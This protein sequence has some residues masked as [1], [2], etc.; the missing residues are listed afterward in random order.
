MT[1]RQWHHSNF[2]D[3]LFK[4][5]PAVVLF[6]WRGR[7]LTGQPGGQVVYFHLPGTIFTRHGRAGINFVPSQG[8]K[9]FSSSIA[10]I[11]SWFKYLFKTSD[12]RFWLIFATFLG[13]CCHCI[14]LNCSRCQKQ[15]LFRD[16]SLKVSIIWCLPNSWGNM[17]L[18]S[19]AIIIY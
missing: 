19:F 1:E 13:V 2:N 12:N 17:I 3:Y 11:L 15:C 5:L 8:V 14:V 10:V 4:F 16:T 9:L 18:V 7:S 6:I